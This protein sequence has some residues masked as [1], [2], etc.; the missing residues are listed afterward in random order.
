VVPQSAARHVQECVRGV[1]ARLQRRGAGNSLARRV[2]LA[3]L[4]M[5]EMVGNQTFDFEQTQEVRWFDHP[6]APT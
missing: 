3:Q 4:R 2:L 1:A 5:V 6:V